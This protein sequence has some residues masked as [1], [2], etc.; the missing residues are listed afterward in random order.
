MGAADENRIEV[1]EGVL[2]EMR[3]FGATEEDIERWRQAMPKPEESDL[4][5]FEDCMWSATVFSVMGSQWDRA[6]MDGR[7]VG[8]MYDRAPLFMR[9][10]GV[11][12]GERKTVFNDLI[13]MENETLE[14]LAE[15]AGT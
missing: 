13:T 8:L 6:G 5:V 15:R 9:M 12:I 10:L 1:D 3:L 2:E 14:V 7:K 4:E 11:P